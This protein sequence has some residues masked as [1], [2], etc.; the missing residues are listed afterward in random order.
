MSFKEEW[1]NSFK[2]LL[3]PSTHNDSPTRPE[4]GPVLMNTDAD[5]DLSNEITLEEVQAAVRASSTSKS[6]GVDGI[7][8]LFH[9]IN[10]CIGFLHLFF[11]YCFKLGISFTLGTIPG[12]SVCT[13][14][15]C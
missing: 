12:L 9:K 8:P 13:T 4:L 14:C 15:T 3:N 5:V 2:E 7:Q 1:K 10:T 6:P 11:N